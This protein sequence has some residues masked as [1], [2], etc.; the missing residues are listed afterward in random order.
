MIA[1]AM[2]TDN[3]SN[4]LKSLI[5][6]TLEEEKKIEEDLDFFLDND[7]VEI[8]YVEITKE[9]KWKLILHTTN[10]IKPRNSLSKI[11]YNVAKEE[12]LYDIN[13]ILDVYVLITKNLNLVSLERKLF[14]VNNQY[15]VCM[16]WRIHR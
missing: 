7:A 3:I 10:I 6:K 14:D 11:L 1:G 15:I 4:K 8:K 13:F 2:I 9:N 16:L 12:D 5:N